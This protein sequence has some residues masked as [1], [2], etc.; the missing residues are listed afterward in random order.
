MEIKKHVLSCVWEIGFE[1]NMK[2]Q[3]E[4]WQMHLVYEGRG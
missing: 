4:Y 3:N 1:I 2:S